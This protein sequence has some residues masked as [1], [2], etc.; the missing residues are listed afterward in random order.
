MEGEGK[1]MR[2]ERSRMR[3][4]R[5]GDDRRAVERTERGE[6]REEW[7]GERCHCQAQQFS[8]GFDQSFGPLAYLS[9]HPHSPTHPLTTHPLTTPPLS[10][11]EP[12]IQC[13]GL[14]SHISQNRMFIHSSMKR[15]L[16]EECN[17]MKM[18][19]THT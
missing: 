3:R 19:D 1:K 8:Q 16:I 18:T 7:R 14:N 12:S 6:M 15:V 13:L 17:A 5:E 10:P 2:D 11:Q 4:A 9:A